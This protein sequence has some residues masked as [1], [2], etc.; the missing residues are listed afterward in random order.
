[1]TESNPRVI[2]IAGPN[3]AGKATFAHEFYR[4]N[5]HTVSRFCWRKEST[6]EQPKHGSTI[7]S[8]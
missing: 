2:I 3:G 8:N 1:M 6:H 5:P 7:D 4:K